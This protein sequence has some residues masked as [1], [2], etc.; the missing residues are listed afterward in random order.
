MIYSRAVEY[1]IRALIHLAGEPPG[2][3]KMARQVAEEENIP[4][5]FLAKTLQQL[6]RKGILRSV[7]GPA[8]GFGFDRPPGKITLMEIVEVF[9]GDDS[10]DR[11][12]IGLPE[13]NDKAP[14]PVDRS[15]R[16]LRREIVRF[17]KETTIAQLA[18]PPAKRARSTAR[19]AK[20]LGA[21]AG[22]G[23]R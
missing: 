8:G 9:D 10:F 4:S 14:C 19:K 20:A 16:P 23:S 7:K 3:Q 6:A 2:T 12:M 11:C 22:R 18:A 1:A 17:L 5:F 21:K 13:C 15:F